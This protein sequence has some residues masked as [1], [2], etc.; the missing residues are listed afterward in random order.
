MPKGIFKRHLDVSSVLLI[1]IQVPLLTPFGPQGPLKNL[2]LIY[3]R[4]NKRNS[5][6]NLFQHAIEVSKKSVEVTVIQLLLDISAYTFVHQ[7]E[8]TKAMLPVTP[9]CL[10]A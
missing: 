4:G 2:H 9:V 10:K 8:G 5:S 7:S 3:Y 1:A 6:S